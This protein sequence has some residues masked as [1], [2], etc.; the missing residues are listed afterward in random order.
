MQEQILLPPSPVQNKEKEAV[1]DNEQLAKMQEVFLEQ[2]RKNPD[3]KLVDLDEA[4]RGI[5]GEG[6]KKILEKATLNYKDVRHKMLELQQEL[7]FEKVE[8]D[9][10][11]DIF[12]GEELYQHIT[13][14]K[15]NG[16][17][18][19]QFT[20]FAVYMRCEQS[21]DFG[22]LYSVVGVK[23]ELNLMALF[24][25]VEMHQKHA[26]GVATHFEY[27]YPGI[28]VPLIVENT[29]VYGNKTKEE[30]KKNRDS[31]VSHEEQHI[32]NNLFVDTLFFDKTYE[33]ERL[34]EAAIKILR[35]NQLN[36]S[37]GAEGAQEDIIAYAEGIKKQFLRNAQGEFTA[38]LKEG[39]SPATIAEALLRRGFL[40]DYFGQSKGKLSALFNRLFEKDAEPLFSILEEEFYKSYDKDIEAA[41]TLCKTLLTKY[42]AEEIVSHLNVIP[43]WKWQEVVDKLMAAK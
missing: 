16:K 21:S 24:E 18:F 1:Y 40:Y 20:S 27:S 38:Y 37:K 4:M 33:N 41:A 30:M 15:P 8:Q 39:Y 5:G 35:K 2:A 11:G 32:I 22:F 43:I 36:D 31:L 28:D 42:S 29:E 19:I 26:A 12:K 9:E 6:E 23:G 13:G 25:K 10:R 17:I 14:A 34:A 7:S 3:I